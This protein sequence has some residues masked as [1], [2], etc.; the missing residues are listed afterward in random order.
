MPASDTDTAQILIGL[1]AEITSA[2]VS[3]NSV[4]ASEL[5]ALIRSV[6]DAF[7]SVTKPAVAVKEKPE[8]AVPIRSSVKPDYII[9]LEDGAR[10][11]M[12]KRYLRT[13]Y[14]MTPQEYREK[15]DLPANYPMVAPNYA[16]QRSSLAKAIGL[17]RKK[18][19]SA[20]GGAQPTGKSPPSSARG[21]RR[22]ATASG[23]EDV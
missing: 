15:W 11:K 4:P 8:P 12:L 19:E 7:R 3:N 10:L 5:P 13:R 14:G 18:S 22:G 20:E 21:K 6:H 17:G 16:E 9:C 2:H 1:T 23:P